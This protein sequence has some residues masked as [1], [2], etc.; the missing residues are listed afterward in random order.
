MRTLMEVALNDSQT[1]G[2]LPLILATVWIINNAF[3]THTVSAVTIGQYASNKEN[4]QHQNNL[5]D[6]ILGRTMKSGTNLKFLVVGEMYTFDDSENFLN[7]EE[8]L[9]HFF[10]YYSNRERCIWIL[11]G[12]ESYM[13]LEKELL[14]E[15]RHYHRNG[16]FLLVYTGTEPQRLHNI[17]VIFC[18]LFHI[19]VI[20]VNVLMMV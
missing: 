13:R 16:F 3:A 19:Y 18:R 11:D 10:K 5:M 9:G 6:D 14:N 2:Q 15:T 8:R 7:E 1:M 12:L 17:R 20:N 4:Q